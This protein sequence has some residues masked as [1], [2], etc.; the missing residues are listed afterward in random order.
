MASTKVNR[1]PDRLAP[2]KC[3]STQWFLGRGEKSR[4]W[5]EASGFPVFI[6]LRTVEIALSAMQNILWYSWR[7]TCLPS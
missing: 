1:S 5:W 6:K 2:Y 7:I 4:W 3:N